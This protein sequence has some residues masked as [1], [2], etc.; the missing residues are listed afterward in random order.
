MNSLQSSCFVSVMSV[1][2]LRAVG[3]LVHAAERSA[4]WLNAVVDGV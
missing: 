3:K 4:S 2:E 1:I